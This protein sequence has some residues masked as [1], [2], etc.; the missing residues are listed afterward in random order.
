M[1]N[2]PLVHVDPDELE[3]RYSMSSGDILILP[4]L[5]Q[6]CGLL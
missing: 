1:E 4:G 6:A 2:D 3:G 5:P